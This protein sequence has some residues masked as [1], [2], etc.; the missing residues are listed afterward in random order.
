MKSAQKIVFIDTGTEA[1]IGGWVNHH[2]I[3]LLA[4]FVA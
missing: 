4:A 2:M 1:E 3:D